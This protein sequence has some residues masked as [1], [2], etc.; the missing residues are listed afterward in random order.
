MRAAWL[1]AYPGDGLQR[2]RQMHLIRPAARGAVNTPRAPGVEAALGA[3][4]ARGGCVAGVQRVRG[5]C[6]RPVPRCQRQGRCPSFRVVLANSFTARGGN[7]MSV[8]CK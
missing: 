7:Q 6:A 2:V 1:N 4:R 3:R 8:L 5:G